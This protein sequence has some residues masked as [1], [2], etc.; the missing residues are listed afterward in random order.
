M[1][2]PFPA[3]APQCPLCGR[4]SCA[5]YRGYYERLLLCPEMEFFARLVVRTAYCKSLKI[6]FTLL[7]DF[8]IPRRRLSRLGVTRLREAVQKAAHLKDAL[9]DW[10][11]SLPDEF[12]LPVSTAHA[13]LSP[14][15]G[16]P[17]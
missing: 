15:I 6:R 5:V 3:L 17:P 16:V 13:Y 8:V 1:Q 14:R 12:Y 9:D 7:P 2:Y 10:L 11:E 4:P